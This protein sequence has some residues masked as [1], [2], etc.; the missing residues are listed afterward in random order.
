MGLNPEPPDLSGGSCIS[1]G[2]L[3]ISTEPLFHD[4]TAECERRARYTEPSRPFS[5]EVGGRDVVGFAFTEGSD[6]RP[7]TGA[8]KQFDRVFL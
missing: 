3:P 4:S 8:A 6:R 7:V 1:R 2:G 5:V